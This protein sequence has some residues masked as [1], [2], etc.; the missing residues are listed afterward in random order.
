MEIKKEK[1]TEH[2]PEYLK[3]NDYFALMFATFT[4]NI[5]SLSMS[6][7]RYGY[8]FFTP[9]NIPV[10]DYIPFALSVSKKGTAEMSCEKTEYE[11]DNGRKVHRRIKSSVYT[12]K[13]KDGSYS[14]STRYIT[15]PTLSCI[16]HA[17]K[18]QVFEKRD[19]DANGVLKKKVVER[20]LPQEIDTDQDDFLLWKE[21]APLKS[22]QS[23]FYL[24]PNDA[25]VRE[26]NYDD[27]ASYYY[28]TYQE[29]KYYVTYKD[30][31]ETSRQEITEDIYQAQMEQY[32]DTLYDN[33]H[34][35][36]QENKELNKK[37]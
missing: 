22:N 34:M 30:G 32:Y 14:I 6:K 12:E 33:K 23:S 25:V 16:N 24:S 10:A 19:Y 9:F 1:V 36:K 20:Y 21:D 31:K 29:K 5:L 3:D 13:E 27:A 2:F 28:P 11:N 4:K 8:Y 37:F 35:A 15:L 7:Q 17:Q 26:Y 18:I